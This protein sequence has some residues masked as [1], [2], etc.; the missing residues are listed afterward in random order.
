MRVPDTIVNENG[1]EVFGEDDIWPS[2][3]I[4]PVKAKPVAHGAKEAS[5]NKLR[6]GVFTLHGL[7]DASPLFGMS[8]VH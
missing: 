6:A 1:C 2:W 5:D 3:Q 4:F 7:H 8:G